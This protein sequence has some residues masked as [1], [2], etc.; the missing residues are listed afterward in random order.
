MGT[1]LLFFRSPKQADCNPEFP[2]GGKVWSDLRG[3]FV[4]SRHFGG[5]PEPS[6]NG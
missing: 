2:A 1:I 3:H 6:G 4:Y 5:R